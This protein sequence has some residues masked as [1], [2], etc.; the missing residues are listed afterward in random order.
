MN[1][2]I[3][4]CKTIKL[5]AKAKKFTK[6]CKV[7][8]L[9]LTFK[10]NHPD[11]RNS[12]VANVVY[13]LQDYGCNVFVHDPIA[14]SDE[15]EKEYGIKLVSWEKLPKSEVI[16]SAVPH[17]EYINMEFAKLTRM[18]EKKSVTEYNNIYCD[19]LTDQFTAHTGMYTSLF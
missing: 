3:G 13:K 18:G 14:N 17:K 2:K 8:V 10:E 1:Y 16:F 9:G 6:G 5:M 15:A 12:Q 7:I 4:Y 11:L 19:M